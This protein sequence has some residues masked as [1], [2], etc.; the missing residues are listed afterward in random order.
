[1]YHYKICYPRS[2][3]LLKNKYLQILKDIN[4]KNIF[5]NY[6]IKTFTEGKKNRI[7]KNGEEEKKRD[8]IFLVV[9]NKIEKMLTLSTRTS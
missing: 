3:I 4:K 1:M 2:K 7:K 9:Y 6:K 5:I 8:A